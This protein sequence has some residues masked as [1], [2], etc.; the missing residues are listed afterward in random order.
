MQHTVAFWTS[1][2]LVIMDANSAVSELH[3][4]WQFEVINVW[5]T[6]PALFPFEVLDLCSCVPDTCCCKSEIRYVQ[7][8]WDHSHQ[9]NHYNHYR[10][11]LQWID[12]D[13]HIDHLT[14]NRK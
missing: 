2:T 13:A 4:G 3:G 8:S 9:A 12:R 10:N 14:V 5:I 1:S 11:K 7:G 6:Q